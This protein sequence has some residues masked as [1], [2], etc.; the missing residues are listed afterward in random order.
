MSRIRPLTKIMEGRTAI[1]RRS[2]GARTVELTEAVPTS[3]WG[4]R[5]TP[6]KRVSFSCA[7]S[8]G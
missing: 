2:A 1:K 3:G 4:D 7:F 5:W 6:A 8:G